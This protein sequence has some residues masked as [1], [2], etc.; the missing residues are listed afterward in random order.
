M[1]QVGA[2]PAWTLRLCSPNTRPETK[3]KEEEEEEEEEG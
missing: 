1:D 2:P 3:K